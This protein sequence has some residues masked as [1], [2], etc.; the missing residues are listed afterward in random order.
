[1]IVYHTGVG[2]AVEDARDGKFKIMPPYPFAKAQFER[3]PEWADV[4]S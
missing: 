2:R 4:L 3:T 1:M